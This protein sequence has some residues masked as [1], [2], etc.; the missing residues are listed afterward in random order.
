[1][2]RIL[3]LTIV[4]WTSPANTIRTRTI[5]NP[6][7]AKVSVTCPEEID[8]TKPIKFTAKVVGGKR[9][10]EV[11]YNWTVSKGTIVFGQGTDSIQVDLK[12]EDC[13]GVTATVEVGGLDPSCLRSASCAICDSNRPDNLD[14][15][16]F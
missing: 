2:L 16:I 6:D 11:A 13:R 7:C 14:L 1:M 5:Q 9:F 15:L 8:A 10:G 3:I 4:L 12:G